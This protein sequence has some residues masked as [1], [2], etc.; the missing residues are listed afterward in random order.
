MTGA[1]SGR[2]NSANLRVGGGGSGFGV[3]R[4]TA[5]R[6]REG[7]Q[8]RARR[9]EETERI[10]QACCGAVS[11]SAP[12]NLTTAGDRLL[13]LKRLKATELN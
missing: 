1:Q 7:L 8:V 13:L 4:G 2:S 12:D 10:R 6:Q 3:R 5:A 9:R 11:N